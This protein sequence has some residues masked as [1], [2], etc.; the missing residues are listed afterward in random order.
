MGLSCL[1]SHRAERV[2]ADNCVAPL[3]IEK[4]EAY[5]GNGFTG[6]T[7]ETETNGEA[8]PPFPSFLL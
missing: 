4:A 1:R 5:G 7:E 2:P 8:R 3:D 6:A